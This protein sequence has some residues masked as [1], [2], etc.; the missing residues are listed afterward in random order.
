MRVF[1]CRTGE[2][3][4]LDKIQ[5]VWVW[6]NTLTIGL[7]VEERDTYVMVNYDTEEQRDAAFRDAFDVVGKT[8]T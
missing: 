5:G 7:A 4:P 6:K 1:D 8:R 3:I 2:Y